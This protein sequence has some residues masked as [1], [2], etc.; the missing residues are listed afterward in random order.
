MKPI[1][2]NGSVATAEVFLLCLASGGVEAALVLGPLLGIF[3]PF[4]NASGSQA[5]INIYTII[6]WTI[7]VGVFMFFIACC[8]N[9]YYNAKN[10]SDMGV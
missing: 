9:A 6:Y 8:V 3:Q 2:D 5:A 1:A 4:Y 7:V 10:E